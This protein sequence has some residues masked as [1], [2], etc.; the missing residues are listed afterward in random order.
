[1]K[2]FNVKKLA[3]IATGAVLLGTAIA[4][5]VSA[6]NV[7]KEDIYNKDG[8]PKVNIV[9]GSEAAVSDAVWAGNLAA[10]IAEKAYTTQAVEVSATAGDGDIGANL[11]LS[12]LTVDVTVGGT[13]TFGAGSK[14]YNVL[15]NSGSASGDTEVLTATDSSDTNALTDAQL[16]HLFNA[17]LVQKVNNGDQ[18]NQ[19][20]SLTV[21]ELIGVD[22]DARFHTDGSTIKDIVTKIDSGD[23]SYKVVIG[24]ST[25]G[26]DLGSTSFT[27]GS[28]DNVKVVFF[29]EEYELNTATLTGAKNLKLVKTSAKESYNEGESIEGLVG[30]NA[31]DGQEVTV[32]VVQI[33]QTGAASASYKA[34]FEIYDAEG[35]LIDTQTVAQGENLRSVF[36]DNSGNEALTSNLYV[37]T[38]AV[39]STTGVGYVEI[40]KG[41]DTLELLDGKLY[42]YD[43]TVSTGTKAY[44]V[45]ITA[46]TSDANSLYSI[47]VR[48]SSEKWSSVGGDSYDFGPLYPTKSEQSLTGKTGKQAVFLQGL[49]D[50]TA[51][52][53]YAKVEFVGFE[54]KE[55]KTSVEIGRGVS[56]LAASSV[57]GVSFRA[58]NDALRQI[59]FYVKMSDTNAGSTF[60]FEG[61]DVWYTMRFATGSGGK[62]TANDYNILVQTDD[63]INGRT[64]TITNANFDNNTALSIAGIGTVGD[65]VNGLQ[66]SQG[67]APGP[68][69]IRD[70]NAF[71]VDGVLY[72]VEDANVGGRTSVAMIVSVDN[73]AEFRLNNDTGTLLF[74]TAGNVAADAS[75]GL[76]ALSNNVVFDGNQITTGA[77]NAPVTLGLYTQESSRLVYY[78]AKYN[79]VTDKLFLLLDADKLGA[80]Q[81]NK[82][83]NNHEVW[84]LGT[85]IPADDGT[86]T[87]A[88][89]ADTRFIGSGS[90]DLNA[91]TPDMH[92]TNI[93]TVGGNKGQIRKIS[94]VWQYGHY[95]PKDTDFNAS[96]QNSGLYTSSN[97][98]FVA[99]F[100]VNDA[101]SNGDFNAYIDTSNGGNLG[102]FGGSVTNNLSGYSYDV[103]YRGSPNWNLTSGSQSDYLSAGYTDAGAKV[104]LLA[105]DAG[106]K[107]SLPQAAEK[108]NI[109]I[110]GQELSRE[111]EGGQTLTLKV[112]QSGTT[113]SGTK[114]TVVTVNGGSCSLSGAEGAAVCSADPSSAAVPAGVRNP[115][116]YLDNQAPSGTNI[117]IGGHIVNKLASG[118]ADRLTAPGQKVAE[119]DA[120]TGDIYLAG[121][122][123]ADT[124]SA[125]QELIDDIDS[126]ES[127]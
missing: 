118:L 49:P 26:V 73:V 77:N 56:G 93:N 69:T 102:P 37:E 125:V 62:D 20:T 65:D 2:G 24:A 5:L 80:G 17:S 33:V 106:G 96:S 120:A 15:L 28:D 67:G 50:G 13:V 44:N 45:I 66:Q 127:A 95:V 88:G 124:G 72:K 103:R 64:W 61:K 23:F 19:S 108:I 113:D 16:P 105:D 87:E 76:M 29:G 84:F 111:V 57:G 98:Y 91:G 34:T 48:N 46:G 71:T 74:N 110:Y 109:V 99:E 116:V 3:A 18:S 90:G 100:I 51:G 85:V 121:Y 32:K 115:I 59:P 107:F 41:T 36:K 117:V 94:S 104:W 21:K 83:Q 79:A 40:T 27:D 9:V 58:D 30:D 101:V 60:N 54:D 10:K 82:I 12:N 122:T 6:T 70:L 112:G 1:M 97:A 123:A 52:K 35:N 86:Y 42:P 7:T 8:S 81:S 119:A 78:A 31:Y 43:S 126:W 75:Y 39:G 4:P 68:K 22:A 11:D 55:E 38:I 14:V 114:L 53:G 89:D 47:E 25:T 63:V 92:D